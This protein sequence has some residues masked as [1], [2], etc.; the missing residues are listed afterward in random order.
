MVFDIDH[1]QQLYLSQSLFFVLSGLYFYSSLI[2][3]KH[4]QYLEI[5]VQ[6]TVNY[7]AAQKT[8]VAKPDNR[9]RPGKAGITVVKICKP[10]FTG[11]CKLL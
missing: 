1:E 7:V 2:Q 3:V 6:T 11:E 5:A 4:R 8:C 10:A 9:V